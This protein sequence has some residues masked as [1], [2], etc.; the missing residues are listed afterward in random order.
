MDPL[1][2]L[3]EKPA[4]MRRMTKWQL[5]LSE[6]NITYV[7]QK[8]NGDWKTKDEK[9]I[10]YHIYL[11]N[12]TEE[13]EEITF[14]Y[15]LRTKNQFADALATLASMLEIPKGVVEWELTFKLHEELTFYLQID[16]AE[17]S[18]N[19]QPWYIDIKEYLEH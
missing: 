19:D 18:S 8:T 13:F 4:L 1:K 14:S 7:N 15:M 9:L 12:L 3:F 16:E 10:P 17:T 11:E 6:F 5:L 2:Y